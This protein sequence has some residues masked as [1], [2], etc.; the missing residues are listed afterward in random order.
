MDNAPDDNVQCALL[1]TRDFIAIMTLV[2]KSLGKTHL[3]GKQER[4]ALE[5]LVRHASSAYDDALTEWEKDDA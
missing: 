1:D 3:T 4:A 2:V 5:T